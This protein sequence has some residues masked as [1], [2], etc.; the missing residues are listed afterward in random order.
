MGG[1]GGGEEPRYVGGAAQRV[2]NS[3]V[4]CGWVGGSTGV[5]VVGGGSVWWVLG[6]ACSWVVG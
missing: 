2:V 3:L 6:E 5:W 1:T 4:D